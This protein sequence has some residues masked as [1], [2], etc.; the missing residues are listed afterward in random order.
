M[1]I[2]CPLC[3]EPM[4]ADEFYDIAE[5]KGSSFKDV[6]TDFQNRGCKALSVPGPWG[7]VKCNFTDEADEVD[8]VYGLTAAQAA[9]ALY[10]LLGDD[11]DGAA[12]MLGDMG[13]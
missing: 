8:P 13:F 9:S 1:D 3:G 12:A 2:R 5:A 7:S 6:L 10:D 4:D 11:V